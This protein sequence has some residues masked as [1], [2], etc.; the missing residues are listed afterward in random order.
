MRLTRSHFTCSLTPPFLAA[1]AMSKLCVQLD[2]NTMTTANF[3]VPFLREIIQTID[4]QKWNKPG[5]LKKQ[6][7]FAGRKL[8]HWKDPKVGTSGRTQIPW[9]R[10]A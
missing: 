3:G 1:Y 9:K 6:T 5:A 2:K 7:R 8:K 10:R 4:F